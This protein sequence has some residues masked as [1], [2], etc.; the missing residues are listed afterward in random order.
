MREDSKELRFLRRHRPRLHLDQIRPHGLGDRNEHL[1]TNHGF[2]EY[3]GYLYHLN[4]MEDPFYYTYPAA[5]KDTVGPRNLVHSF[6]TGRGTTQQLIRVGARL[7]SR[8]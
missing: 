3:F 1:P 2:D 5:W 8:R 7:A 6:A 4:A